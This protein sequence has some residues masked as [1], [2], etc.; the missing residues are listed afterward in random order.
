M[1]RTSERG[2]FLYSNHV[3]FGLAVCLPRPLEEFA[4]HLQCLVAVF[5]YTGSA[6]HSRTLVYFC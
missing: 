1:A 4:Q 3:G 2:W 6:A 5:F